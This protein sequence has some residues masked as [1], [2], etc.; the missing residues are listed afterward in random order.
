MTE[1]EAEGIKSAMT[2]IWTA[3]NVQAY[4]VEF[5]LHKPKFISFIAFFENCKV[6]Q[7]V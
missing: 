7:Y 3:V 1:S 5:E 6:I 2:P 4:V